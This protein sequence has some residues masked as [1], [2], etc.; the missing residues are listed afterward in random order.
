MVSVNSP[1]ESTWTTHWI[2]IFPGPTPD[3]LNLHLQGWE[4][5]GAIFLTGLWAVLFTKAILDTLA[6]RTS[7]GADRRGFCFPHLRVLL[8]CHKMKQGANWAGASSRLCASFSS[9]L[10][11]G[12]GDLNLGD[13]S[14]WCFSPWNPLRED[15]RVCLDP[16]PPNLRTRITWILK[17]ISLSCVLTHCDVSRTPRLN[18]SFAFNQE[19]WI[20]LHV[21]HQ[22]FPTAQKTEWQQYTQ[23]AS[24]WGALNLSIISIVLRKILLC[25]KSRIERPF[26]WPAKALKLFPIKRAN[27]EV[28]EFS[29]HLVYVLGIWLSLNQ[30]NISVHIKYKMILGCP[31][32]HI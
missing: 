5:W 7:W 19:S 22:C 1:N 26:Q 29:H 13:Y 18:Y 2:Y 10:P 27:S 31:P 24:T 25:G 4:S 23:W 16:L 14:L 30:K 28:I 21:I 11:T 12:T 3:P 9:C 17:I 8:A 32:S 6:W 15:W 20:I